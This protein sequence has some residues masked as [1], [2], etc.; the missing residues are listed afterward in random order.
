MLKLFDGQIQSNLG[1]FG[2]LKGE[3]QSF[4][5]A[6][7]NFLHGREQGSAGVREIRELYKDF[8]R[9]ANQAGC[10]TSSAE[11]TVEGY[12]TDTANP[13]RAISSHL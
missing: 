3:V 10:H 8:V 12:G 11:G 9:R 2:T 1:E 6:Y 7:Q 13:H 4:W 5:E